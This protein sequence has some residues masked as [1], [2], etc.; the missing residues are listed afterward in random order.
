MK[1]IRIGKDIV[2][3]WAILTNGERE[4]LEDKDLKMF[5]V[6]PIGLK[7]ELPLSVSGNIITSRYKG[8]EQKCLGEY[9]MTLW[10]NFGKDNQ[11]AVDK[12]DVFQLV[13]TSCEEEDSDKGLAFSVLNLSTDTNLEIYF[14]KVKDTNEI[15]I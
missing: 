6:S 13:P 15:N 5:L 9:R 7:I 10:E 8:T 12:C 14:E 3:Q 11:S 2:I 1:K 4:N